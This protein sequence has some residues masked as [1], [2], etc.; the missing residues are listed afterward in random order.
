MSCPKQ[1]PFCGADKDNLFGWIENDY[2][3]KW[4]CT[5]C[6]KTWD[7]EFEFNGGKQPSILLD[8]APFPQAKISGGGTKRAMAKLKEEI[9]KLKKD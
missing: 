9:N 3:R 4:E 8:E 5:R 2:I 1:C 6:G 7:R